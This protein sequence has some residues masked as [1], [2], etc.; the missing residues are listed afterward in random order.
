MAFIF[1]HQY[2]EF[3]LTGTE[4]EQICK[5]LGNAKLREEKYMGSGVDRLVFVR[6]PTTDD[7]EMRWIDDAVVDTLELVYKMQIAEKKD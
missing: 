5:V 4:V 3:V 7:L 2:K 6:P 1:K